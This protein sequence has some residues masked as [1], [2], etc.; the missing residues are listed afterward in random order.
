MY[1]MQNAQQNSIKSSD[2]KKSALFIVIALFFQTAALTQSCLPDGITFSTQ[3]EIDNF[4]VNYPNCKTIEG[5]VRI[6]GDDITNLDGI[7]SITRID[8]NIQIWLNP[9]LINLSGLS[10][11]TSIGYYLDIR[12]NAIITDLTGLNSLTSIPGHLII[13]GNTS[14][15]N[16]TGLDNLISIGSYF[17]IIDNPV[18]I[19]ITNLLSLQSIGTSLMIDH[20]NLLTNL[21]GLDASIENLILTY[22]PLLTTCNVESICNHLA[23]PIGYT[24][25]F[26]NATGCMTATEII[27]E[28]ASWIPNLNTELLF[29]IHP[30][31][32][33]KELFISSENEVLVNE[34]IIYSKLGQSI[35][36]ETVITDKIDISTLEQGIYVIELVSENLRIRKKLIIQ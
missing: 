4:E 13:Q 22:N 18:L 32:A 25:I 35:L 2:M 14:L 20:N 6:K 9:N 34:V 27:A 8:G 12:N 15:I 7:H 24:E 26:D 31:P 28:C 3:S 33:K 29:N 36:H 10:N 5:D 19:S 30:N 1:V 16:L 23:N 21:D 17:R 11:L